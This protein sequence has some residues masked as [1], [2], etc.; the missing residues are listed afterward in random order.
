[1]LTEDDFKAQMPT[2]HAGNYFAAAK[3]AMDHAGVDWATCLLAKRYD[4]GRAVLIVTGSTSDDKEFQ[5]AEIVPNDP[6]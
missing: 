5:W 1:M 4:D 6:A 3:A 2:E